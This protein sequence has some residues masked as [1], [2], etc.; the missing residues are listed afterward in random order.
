[1][2]RVLSKRRFVPLAILGLVVAV[3]ATATAALSA[4]T[5]RCSPTI[6]SEPFGSADGEA[7]ELYTLTNCNRHGRQ[8]HD[9]R[10]HHH[11]SIV[12]PDRDGKL[13]NVTLGL[14]Q[15]RRLP[16][17]A[18]RTSAASPAAY[19]NRIAQGHSSRSTAR[20]TSSRSTTARTTCTAARRA[21][22]RSSGTATRS[23]DADGVGVR[24]QPHQPR[25]RGGL[26]RH[27]DGRRSPTR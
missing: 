21:S 22:T 6:T 2:R 17:R 25:R 24:A 5:A 23:H 16:G 19:A 1:M 8:D 9:L 7:V 18:S 20:R 15:P 13:A 3:A 26:S 11:R 27:S 12:V 10:R 14:R 4:S